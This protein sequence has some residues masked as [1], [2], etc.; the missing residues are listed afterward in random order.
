MSSRENTNSKV[1]VV[2]KKAIFGLPLHKQTKWRLL[3]GLELLSQSFESQSLDDLLKILEKVCL[4]RDDFSYLSKLVGLVAVER[5]I[6]DHV[7]ERKSTE[8]F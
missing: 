3:L 5:S 8:H 2:S 7:A 6:G 1:I 4:T